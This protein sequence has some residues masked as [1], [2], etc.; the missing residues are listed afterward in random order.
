MYR[1]TYKFLILLNIIFVW[2]CK[3]ENTIPAQT[4]LEDL[5]YRQINTPQIPTTNNGTNSKPPA[6]TISRFQLSPNH[7]YKVDISGISANERHISYQN[8][9]N[10]NNIEEL[11]RQSFSK[12]IKDENMKKF[13]PI[14]RD[15]IEIFKLYSKNQVELIYMLSSL[16]E[17]YRHTPARDRTYSEDY[18]FPHDYVQYGIK[19]DFENVSMMSYFLYS[20]CLQPTIV[21]IGKNLMNLRIGFHVLNQQYDKKKIFQQMNSGLENN[22]GSIDQPARCNIDITPILKKSSELQFDE[23][24]EKRLDVTSSITDDGKTQILTVDI[25]DNEK[26]KPFYSPSVLIMDSKNGEWKAMS[27]VDQSPGTCVFRPIRGRS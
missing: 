24:V 27:V 3:T 21:P 9:R 25:T 19:S 26:L 14:L 2:S 1:N 5:N 4:F 15:Y 8:L 18:Y 20:V 16:L 6:T 13:D 10:E 23:E 22:F 7:E 17:S 11:F 12:S